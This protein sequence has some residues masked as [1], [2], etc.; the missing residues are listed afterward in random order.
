[1]LID[2]D[3]KGRAISSFRG[4]RVAL[5][6]MYVRCPLPD[7][8]PL[9]DR[10]FAAEQKTIAATPD[11]KD[12]QLVSVS[13]DTGND[14]PAVLKRHAQGLGADCRRGEHARN[15]GGADD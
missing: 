8:C 10:N 14:T 12:V 11:L 5:T 3:G 13:F 15:T 4:L 7:F 2:Q 9:M 6:F 1:M